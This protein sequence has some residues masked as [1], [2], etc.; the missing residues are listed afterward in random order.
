MGNYAYRLQRESTMVSLQGPICSGY[1]WC[2]E[3]PMAHPKG[4][5]HQELFSG[6]EVSFEW[7]Y[8]HGSERLPTL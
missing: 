8:L 2:L 7:R 4:Q 3:M 1:Q 6:G 5:E